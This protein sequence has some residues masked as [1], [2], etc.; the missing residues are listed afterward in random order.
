MININLIIL[1]LLPEKE[2]FIYT[3]QLKYTRSDTYPAHLEA[4]HRF[5][6]GTRAEVVRVCNRKSDASR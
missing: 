4:S 5:N 1:K 6:N 3:I 2:A